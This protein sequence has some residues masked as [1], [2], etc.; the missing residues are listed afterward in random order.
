MSEQ[1]LNPLERNLTMKRQILAV[2]LGSFI[3][4]PALANNEIDAGYTPL[5]QVAQSTEVVFVNAEQGYAFKAQMAD[6]SRADVLA[7][8]TKARR[9]GD[10]IV[11]AELGT[12]ASQL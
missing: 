5:A 9:S 3:A 1:Q 11:N 8:V 10:Y 12:K 7:E 6:K 4:L 2:A